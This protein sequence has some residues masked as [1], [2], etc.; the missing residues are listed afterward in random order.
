MGIAKEKKDDIAVYIENREYIAN[1][2]VMKCFF[3]T[4]VFYVVSY[5]LNQ[6]EI[7]VVNKEVMASGFF[8]SLI[9]Y[10]VMLFCSKQVSLSNEKVKYFILFAVMV[11]Y[12]IMGVTITY[13]VV[14]VSILPLLYATLYS[15]KRVMRYIYV[16]T[17][18]STIIIVYG[19]YY[20]GLCD[21]N[22]TLLTTGRLG[23]YN[24]NGRFALSTVNEN[25]FYTLFLFF[26]VPR[27][28][29]HFAFVFVCNNIIRIVSG[30]LEKA[31]LT[32]ELEKAK[33]E[34][35]NA[36]LAKSKFLARMSH[37]IRT[38]INAIFGMNEMILRESKEPSIR[39][40][41][42]DAK[43]AS[44]IL[45][46]II[47]E[48][49]DSSKIES[50]MM[51]LVPVNYKLGSLLNDIYNM[52]NVRAKEK[53][54]ELIFDI[55]P[56]MPKEYYGDDKR[57]RQIL[58]NL[59]NNGVKYTNKGQV[60]LKI[61]CDVE[62]DIAKLHCSVK[63]TGIGI[64]P[65]DVGK[66]YDEFKR[67]D[68]RRNRNVEGSGLGMNIAQQFL[69]L[70]GSELHITSEYEKGSEFF[71]DIEQKIVDK[72]PLGDFHKRFV[73]AVDKNFRTSFMAPNAKVLIVDDVKMNRTVVK[74]LLRQTRIQIFEAESGRECLEKLAEES[75]HM[76]FLDHM[77]PEMDGIET[78]H[79]IQEM[80]L[81]RGVPIIM[82]TANAIL[83]DREMYIKEGFDDFLSKPIL[84][85]KLEEMILKYL[86]KELVVEGTY[87][88]EEDSDQ[89]VVELPELDE[90][91]FSYAMGILQKEELL[92]KFLEDFHHSLEPLMQKL[93]TLYEGIGQEENLNA[94]R[95][96]VHTLKSTAA[97]VGA[98]LLSKTA[99]LLE[100]AA[101]ER[102]I[103]KLQALH[104][105]LLEEIK[106]HEVR[107]ASIMQPK[108]EKPLAEK[109]ET[110]YLDMLKVSLKNENYET[111]DFICAEI[112]KYQ[113]P[114]QVQALVDRL[115][116]KVFQLEAE[117]ALQVIEE[118][119]G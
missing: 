76:I 118:I 29:I 102:D 72:E 96:E 105:V 111:A 17:V 12:T 4:M 108:E 14:L 114:K 11:V 48:I 60:I 20:W 34:A 112:Q 2:Y 16:L 103:I 68:I 8:P 18:I 116:E 97:T 22:M 104:P 78:K 7:F 41:A 92:Y 23:E 1:Q 58:I 79:K 10:F 59:L 36:N 52:M 51:E 30:S 90:F 13:H 57:I 109:V 80:Q 65:E 95:A 50:G 54:L 33:T 25:P 106:K 61:T 67:I 86:P 94:Y 113:Y 73:Q 24:I 45:L 55:D 47:N 69:Q 28:L 64:K 99:R 74:T 88:E 32:A 31:K 19:G 119:R 66:L 9:I 43:D 6:L 42:S 91:D 49:L 53:K 98:L 100:I 46:S 101:V 44:E 117:E 85:N 70:M 84:V 21:A 71:F 3:I 87:A 38:P 40:Y 56:N 37:E 39:K 81:C 15:S 77:M 89:E 107:I 27:S 93:E 35:E 83:E 26:V 62:G 110:A 75:F 82:L 63:D 115:L 5:I